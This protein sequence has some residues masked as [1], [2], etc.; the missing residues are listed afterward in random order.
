M[1][2]RSVQLTCIHLALMTASLP[3]SI[4]GFSTKHQRFSALPVFVTR[5]ETNHIR[6]AVDCQHEAKILSVAR[7]VLRSG[8]QR[9][10]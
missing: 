6:V 7:P 9:A 3:S 8:F 5:N 1:M 2:F 4:V 10:G